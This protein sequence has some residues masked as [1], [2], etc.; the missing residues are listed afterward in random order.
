MI[1]GVLSL[2]LAAI[3]YHLFVHITITYHLTS[4]DSR[5]LLKIY[6]LLTY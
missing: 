6:I 1:Y 5:I 3:R 2:N 4:T